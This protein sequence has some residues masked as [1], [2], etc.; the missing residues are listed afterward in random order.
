MMQADQQLKGRT[1]LIGNALHTMT[2]IAAQGLNLALY[3]IAALNEYVAQ[4]ELDSLAL[5]SFATQQQK[6]STRLSHH[7]SWL[8]SQDFFIINT[9]RQLGMISLDLCHPL[10]DRFARHALGRTGRI[11]ILLRDQEQHDIYKT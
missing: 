6:M 8:F 3:E 10:K 7:L 2:P 11:P 1:I 5:T 4:H 9:A